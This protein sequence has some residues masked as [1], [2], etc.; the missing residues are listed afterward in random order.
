MARVYSEFP[1]SGRHGN[2][3]YFT[4]NGKTFMKEYKEPKDPKTP[5]QLKSRARLRATG[6]FLKQFKN[7]IRKGYQAPVNYTSSYMEAQ[8]YVLDNCLKPVGTPDDG[9]EYQFEIDIP[10]LK[11]SRG[12]ITPPEINAIERNENEL[13]LEWNK[14][15]GPQ[16]NRHYDS[17]NIVAY[18][19]GQN[20]IWLSDIGTRQ[21]GA[22]KCHLPGTIQEPVHLWA[23]FSNEQKTM[24]PNQEN[25]SNSIYLGIL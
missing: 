21:D 14:S 13:S 1:F 18:A 7:I 3:V 2:I 8:K 12:R 16:P 6:K 4:R 24:K 23:F 17:L 15:L 11:L 25:I 19:T 9:N 5:N 22:G 10:S 20:V